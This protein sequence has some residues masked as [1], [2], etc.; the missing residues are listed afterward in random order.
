MEILGEG[1]AAGRSR[2]CR[3]EIPASAAAGQSVCQGEGGSIGQRSRGCE[4]EEVTNSCGVAGEGPMA[5]RGT[6]GDALE[7]A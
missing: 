6:G 2:G 4:E 7:Q 5:G 3:A 1:G